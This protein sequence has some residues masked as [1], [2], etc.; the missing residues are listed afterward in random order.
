M[1]AMIQPAS[2]PELLQPSPPELLQQSAGPS[3]SGEWLFMR[4]DYANVGRVLILRNE[5]WLANRFLARRRAGRRL[6]EAGR[7]AQQL[8]GPRR[9]ET[10]RD[11]GK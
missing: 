10:D 2:P 9:E 5:L 1:S 6:A 4:S 8:A 11:C 3:E 7:S